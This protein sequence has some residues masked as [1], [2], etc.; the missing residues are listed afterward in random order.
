MAGHQL[1]FLF[2]NIFF[3]IFWESA[4]QYKPATALELSYPQTL[5]RS[6]PN[7]ISIVSLELSF[8]VDGNR[9]SEAVIPATRFSG[10]NLKTL[11]S[12]YFIN[13]KTI[14]RYQINGIEGGGEEKKLTDLEE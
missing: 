11:D 7:S 14:S 8:P 13:K 9:P 5:S 6:S 3:V 1:F 12:F 2:F 10:V 4:P